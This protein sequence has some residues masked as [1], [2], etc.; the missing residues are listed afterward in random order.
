MFAFSFAAS[1]TV[2]HQCLSLSLPQGK[3]KLALSTIVESFQLLCVCARARVW[4]REELRAFVCVWARVCVRER[5]FSDP[6]SWLNCVRVCPFLS[7]HTSPT[8]GL[9][10]SKLELQQKWLTVVVVVVVQWDRSKTPGWKV[11]AHSDQTHLLSCLR[12]LLLHL[13]QSSINV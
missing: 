9:R 5:G 7:L 1:D 4:E 3:Q 11:W 12:F 6:C 13:T 8:Q 10:I 2:Q